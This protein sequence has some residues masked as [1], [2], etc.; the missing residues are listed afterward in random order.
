MESALPVPACIYAAPWPR[1]PCFS[2]DL[3]RVRFGAFNDARLLG[4]DPDDAIRS[5]S[6]TNASAISS[7]TASGSRGGALTAMPLL[8]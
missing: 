5:A 2:F 6:A 3:R 7:Y 8:R 4:D 1:A